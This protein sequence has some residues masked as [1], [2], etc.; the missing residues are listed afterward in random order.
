MGRRHA[1][2]ALPL[3]CTKMPAGL[4]RHAPGLPGQEHAAGWTRTALGSSG[5]LIL[6][7]P[8]ACLPVRRLAHAP[9]T[10]TRITPMCAS[11]YPCLINQWSSRKHKPALCKRRQA[12][13][14]VCS[15]PAALWPH[16]T[17]ATASTASE[18]RQRGR[19]RL[20]TSPRTSG[21]ATGTGGTDEDEDDT[22]CSRRQ[23]S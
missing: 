16:A 14:A 11:C 18:G 12:V 20:R 7:T 10:S 23:Y 9:A 15:T 13:H 19:D 6:L 21:P 3:C 2:A 5:L 22:H 4:P 17:I 8:P 1:R